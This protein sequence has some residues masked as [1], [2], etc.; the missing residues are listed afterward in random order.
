[1]KD[2]CIILDR[3]CHILQKLQRLKCLPKSCGININLINSYIF[4]KVYLLP[5]IVLHHGLEVN[6][7][8]LLEIIHLCN[9]GIWDGVS[10]SKNTGYLCLIH[11][12]LLLKF[13]TLL[14]LTYCTLEKGDIY[15]KV[16]EALWLQRMSLSWMKGNFLKKILLCTCWI[17][18]KLDN[19]NSSRAVWL[20]W[21]SLYIVYG[22]LR[23]NQTV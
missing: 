14:G 11:L 13:D 17:S 1:M 8:V 20:I 22:R 3:T 2:V 21:I 19:I 5:Q 18:N 9:C 4:V 15:K 7:T 16:M 10:A 6:D 12:P 23:L